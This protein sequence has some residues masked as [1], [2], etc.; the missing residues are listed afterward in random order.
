M[1]IIT[2]AKKNCIAYEYP[3]K[4]SRRGP[5]FKKGK[6]VKLI[7]LFD[8]HHQLFKTTKLQMYGKKEFVRYY[9]SNIV[10][11]LKL[12]KEL[13]FG[14]VRYQGKDCILVSTDLEQDPTAIIRLYSHRFKIECTLREMKQ[15]LGSLSY[16]FWTKS[17]PKLKR[18]HKKDEAHPLESIRG[19]KDRRHILN[20]VQAIEGYVMCRCVALGLLLQILSVKFSKQLNWYVVRHLHTPS[21]E[22]VSEATMDWCLR[23][24][25]FHSLGKNKDLNITRIIKSK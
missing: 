19:E 6:S 14:L 23:K 18:C 11:G 16:Q 5:L 9:A 10:W 17:M 22:T 24:S 13:R 8:M 15:V 21:K 3:I 2:K 12:Y 4:K 25:V 1:Y 20:T 7:E